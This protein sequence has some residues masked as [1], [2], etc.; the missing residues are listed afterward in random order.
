M[1]EVLFIGPLLVFFLLLIYHSLKTEGHRFTLL[2]FGIALSFAFFRELIIGLTFPLYFGKFKIGPIGPAIVLGWVFA[3]Y[4]AHYFI[5]SI[6]TNTRFENNLVVKIG[7]GT[8]VVLGISFIMET[9]APLLE[10][11]SWKA[12][13]I[14]SLP[15]GALLLGAPIFVFIG[16]GITGA[17]FFTI[18]YILELYEYKLKGILIDLVIFFV[19]ISNFIICNYI[20]LYGYPFTFP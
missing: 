6:T 5:R 1:Y 14:E 17:S 8:F 12:G 2:F 13:L 11:W 19:V 15:P 3:F 4:L 16:W 10:W 7:F 20:I 18:Y 9:T